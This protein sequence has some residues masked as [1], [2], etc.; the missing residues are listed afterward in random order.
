M[1]GRCE[2]CDGTGEGSGGYPPGV[3]GYCDGTG[4]GACSDCRYP[5]N[6]S[7]PSAS[8]MNHGLTEAE[9]QHGRDIRAMYREA[10]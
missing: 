9:R 4:A 3:C 10:V 8:C 5:A 7:T 2:H 6:Q 1:N